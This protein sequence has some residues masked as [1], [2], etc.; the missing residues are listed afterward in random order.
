MSL[1][2]VFV[3]IGADTSGLEDGI[4]KSKGLAEGLGNGLKNAMKLG[5]AAI[6]TATTAVGAFGMESIKSY[7]NYEQLVGGV[8][9][10][11]GNA[12]KKLQGYANEAYKAAGMS[13][14]EY[15][16]TATQFSASLISSLG[17]DVEA[18]ADMTDVAMR[19]M[20]DNVNV[21]G[22]NMED[23]SNAFKGFSKQNYTMLDNLKL[24][25][26]GTKE[27]MLRLIDDAN[28]YRESIG[29]TADLSIDSFA[30]IVTAIESV[31]EAQGIAGTTGNEAMKTL[32]GSATATKAA[33]QNV[34][35]AIAGGGDLSAAM[36]SLIT[37]V[38]GEAEGEGLL[39]QIIP[40][41]EVAMEGI[42]DF[43]A[44]AAPFI[45]EKIPELIAAILPDMVSAGLGLLSTVGQT[46]INTV[47]ALMGSIFSEIDSAISNSSFGSAWDGIK[48]SIT[49]AIE[50]IKSSFDT[51]VTALSPI[52]EA[53]GGVVEKFQEWID[54]G[55]ALNEA[56]E[57]FSEGIELVGEGI[58]LF[59]EGL[60]SV[61]DYGV[62]F[63]EWLT[64]GSDG[65]DAFMAV[66]TA[67][68]TIIGLVTAN[69]AAHAIAAGA[70]QVAMMAVQ[71]V[72]NLVAGAQAALNAV[73]AANPIGILVVAI[74][75]LVAAL[76]YL[77]NNNE[78]VR[79]AIDAAWQGI[80]TVVEVAIEGIKAAL[81]AIGEFIVTTWET[82]TSAV[83]TAMTTINTVVSTAWNA[84]GTLI[85]T[86]LTTISTTI[87]TIWSTITSTISTKMDNI[88]TKIT[89]VWTN[90]KTSITSAITLI[91]STVTNGFTTM[92]SNLTTPLTNMKT[93]IT[94]AFN[95]VKD[96]I[97]GVI[98]S[99]LTWGSDLIDNFVSGIKN[100]I[101]KVGDA[102]GG[103]AD[104]IKSLIGFSEPEDGPLSRFHTFAPDM[105][106]LFA[107][108]IDQS[109]Y[110]VTDALKRNFDFYDDI[111]RPLNIGGGSASG[112][113]SSRSGDFNETIN[114]Y[115]PTA[116]DPSEVARQTRKANRE[117]MLAL[118]GI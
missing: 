16:E 79:A 99:A 75:A 11:Y 34:I 58:S 48:S 18:A 101:S 32:E 82:V 111:V 72:T 1:M 24:G 36:D 93:A 69:M 60:A 59:L 28:E 77:Y 53:V 13:A 91:K 25:Y 114:I 62:Q 47:P 98:D 5:A 96:T 94:G 31:Q 54:S 12:S 30:D 7:A 78:T 71:G 106:E 100:N 56:T 41:I 22:S 80:K 115:A 15:M 105:M 90:I 68:A 102:I 23:V 55:D 17:G 63:T 83:E 67:I 65:A 112:L 3:K 4:T 109:A 89:T 64:S 103:V 51:L 42:G 37:S 40:R 50:G 10:L 116:L 21:F 8:D 107:Q 70:Y 95:S 118:R 97:S 66:L 81:Y 9:K 45:T 2:D 73:M 27:E 6:G 33:W 26:G 14:N 113:I 86:T 44:T 76:V 104:K 110:L 57:L 61:I 29:K 117:M 85:S 38:F 19:A 20:S 84:I 108:G 39:N 43:I 74:A 35:T 87:T 92:V 46:I 88:K 49:T 52:T